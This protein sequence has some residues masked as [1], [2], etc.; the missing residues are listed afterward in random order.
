[1]VCVCVF[2]C[3][4]TTKNKVGPK[5]GECVLEPKAIGR[6]KICVW[7]FQTPFK[8]EDSQLSAQSL[9]LC[10]VVVVRGQQQKSEGPRKKTSDLK[11]QTWA[12]NSS[13]VGQVCVRVRVKVRVNNK[14]RKISTYCGTSISTSLLQ[15][16]LSL[17][18]FR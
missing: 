16:F 7:T 4:E 2:V 13:Y 12:T 14:H 5:K 8:P 3:G 1:M 11:Y 15:E 17:C 6:K 18:T 10:L 9:I